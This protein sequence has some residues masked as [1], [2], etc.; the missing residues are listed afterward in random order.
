[1]RVDV[2]KGIEELKKQFSSPTSPH[3]KTARAFGNHQGAVS[4]EHLNY[5]LDEFAFRFNR[6]KSG[7]RGKLFFRLIQQPVT[8]QPVPYQ[9]MV[10]CHADFVPMKSRMKDGAGRKR[11]VANPNLS[12]ARTG[13]RHEKQCCLL[14]A[15]KHWVIGEIA[16]VKPGKYRRGPAVPSSRYIAPET[17][18]GLTNWL[19]APQR[20]C[21]PRQDRDRLNGK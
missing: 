21:V 4:V 7:S 10:K 16:H 8:V 5:Y 15:I 14:V 2:S 17:L 19:D 12:P 6:R 13:T 18:A 20:R 9:A 1:M 3:V 11:S